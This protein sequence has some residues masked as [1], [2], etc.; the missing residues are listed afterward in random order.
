MGR[1]PLVNLAR[2]DQLECIKL[3][4]RFGADINFCAPNGY[5]PIQ[6]ALRVNCAVT[7]SKYLLEH[8]SLKLNEEHKY[9]L[10]TSTRSANARKSLALLQEYG[11][12][13]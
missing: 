1:T 6:E 11:I 7:V 9:A 8:P 13:Y 2:N 10:L 5:S 3:F 12:R 4:E